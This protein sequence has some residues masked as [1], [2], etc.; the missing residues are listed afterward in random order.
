MS[1]SACSC[2]FPL[3]LISWVPAESPKRWLCINVFCLMYSFTL[4]AVVV[5]GRDGEPIEMMLAKQIYLIYDW[6]L[7]TIWVVE[8][9]LTVWWHYSAPTHIV[10][11]SN[12]DEGEQSSTYWSI[13]YTCELLIAVYF[14]C[15]SIYF[16]GRSWDDI[17]GR[18]AASDMLIDIGI[19]IVA[20][21]W[22][23][24]EM[25][26]RWKRKARHQASNMNGYILAEP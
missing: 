5:F 22:M 11:A 4:L 18:E 12:G 7:C 16:L 13:W 26:K 2:T 6:I 1:G 19:N 9:G 17:A 15:S 21:L 8:T 14:F 3:W 10:A 23:S 20:Y 24:F 25:I